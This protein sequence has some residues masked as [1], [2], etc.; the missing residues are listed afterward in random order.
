MMADSLQQR[1]Y[2]GRILF[3]DLDGPSHHVEPLPRDVAEK[4][5]GG[6]GL[7]TWLWYHHQPPQ[8]DACS[9]D[10][11]L[12]VFTGPLT[13]TPSPTAGRFGLVTGRSAPAP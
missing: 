9:P 3:V 10:N 7:A 11:H 8:V 12:I 4:L 5:L 13:G 1:G 6:R 2:A